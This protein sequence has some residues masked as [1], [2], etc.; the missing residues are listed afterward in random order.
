MRKYFQ[1]FR[2][3]TYAPYS[4]RPG[5]F[6]C[7]KSSYFLI[8]FLI[9]FVF[10]LQTFAQDHL[11]SG[12]VTDQDGKAIT[13]VSVTVKSTQIGTSTDANGRF[14]LNVTTTKGVLIFTSIGFATQ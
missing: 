8:N 1:Q 7:K 10:S 6:F 2:H 13:G 4:Q 5:R 11:V 3:L 14:S 9:F 12:T